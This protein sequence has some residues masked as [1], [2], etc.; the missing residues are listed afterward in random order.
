MAFEA[1]RYIGAMGYRVRPDCKIST[2]VLD[3]R[4]GLCAVLWLAVFA[5]CREPVS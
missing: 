3:Q 2:I 1:W 4:R 5:R